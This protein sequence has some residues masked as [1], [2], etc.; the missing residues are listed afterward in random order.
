MKS[1]EELSKFFVKRGFK[2]QKVESVRNEVLQMD[3]AQFLKDIPK[4]SRDPQTILV[5]DWHPSL[6]KVP[7][8]LKEHFHLL[9]SDR[10]LS[11]FFTAIPTVAFRRI[12]TIFSYISIENGLNKRKSD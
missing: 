7:S 6:K 2:P 12:N 11:K 9:K 3:R 10:K 4:P 5:C 8:I 1:S